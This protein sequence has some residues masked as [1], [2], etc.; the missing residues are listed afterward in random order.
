MKKTR[1]Y[2]LKSTLVGLTFIMSFFLGLYVYQHQGPKIPNLV[3]ATPVKPGRMLS[4]FELKKTDGQPL[5]LSHLAGHW[6]LLFFG[7]TQCH[8]ICPT[9]MGMMH[10]VYE[11]LRKD[12]VSQ[13]PE[14]IMISLDGERDTLETMRHYVMGFDKEFKGA[15]GSMPMIQQLT[16]ELGVVY[17]TQSSKKD[18]QIDHSGSL[19]LINPA[20]EV[21]AFFIPPMQAFDIAQD[22]ETLTKNFQI[23]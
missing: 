20:G 5:N 16:Q 14:M 21:V 9:T 6:S 3:H 7:F 11:K 2:Y 12:G 22:I 18:G 10:Q 1:P 19:A 4:A 15:I 8:S 23:R 13:R 17:D